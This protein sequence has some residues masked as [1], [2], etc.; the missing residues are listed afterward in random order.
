LNRLRAPKYPLVSPDQYLMHEN[1]PT[2]PR[3]PGV[4]DFSFL[5]PVGVM[6]SSCTMKFAR[7]WLWAKTRPQVGQSSGPAPLSLSRSCPG[8]TTIM[9]GYDF[10]NGQAP[11]PA[12]EPRWRRTIQHCQ[13]TLARLGRVLGH[14]TRSRLVSQTGQ[15]FVTEPATPQ[16]DRPRHR[17]DC[18]SNRSRRVSFGSQ[19]NDP[20]AKNVALFRRGGSHPRLKHRTIPRRQPD[21]RSFGNH[22]NVES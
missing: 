4:E 12:C 14:G 6:F 13:N 1:A 16:A 17:V 9:S 3:M 20:C 19:Q 15:P 18:P 22:P 8:C 11:G 7:T 5:G 10:R 21:F 2:K